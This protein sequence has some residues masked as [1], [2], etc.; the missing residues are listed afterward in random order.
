MADERDPKVSQRYR[1]LG[2]EEPPREL[3]RS[4]LAAARNAVDR[5]HAPLLVPAG[6]HR[7]Y[8]SLAAAAVLLL[9]VAVTL[10]IERQQPDPEAVA[11]S[12]VPPALPPASKAQNE[13]R[14]AREA[15]PAAK[16]VPAPKAG[17]PQVF[18]PDP[19]P[20]AVQDE[21]PRPTAPQPSGREVRSRSEVAQA[22][23]APQAGAPSAASESGQADS[24]AQRPAPAAGALARLAAE[25]PEKWLERIAELRRQSRHDEADKQLA[26]FRKRYPDYRIAE[27]M[28]EKLERK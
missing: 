5:P 10:H 27:P 18:T 19:K 14:P 21:P 28:L 20:R 2:A 23:S 6:R 22:R 17:P 13:Q 1:E 7:W 9:A 4:I 25:P 8:F 24:A 11:T 16:P 3:D 12:P 15:K 26:E